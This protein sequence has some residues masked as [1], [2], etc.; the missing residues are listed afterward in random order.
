MNEKAIARS[1]DWYVALRDEC[2]AIVV[3]KSKIAQQELT[4]MYLMLGAR[5]LEEA[6]N[7][8]V[9]KI[10]EAVSTDIRIGKANLWA[11]VAVVKKFGANV[12]KL[13]IEGAMVSWSKT[14]RLLAPDDALPGRVEGA[15]DVDPYALANKLWSQHDHE[16]CRI[17]G[18]QL[19]RLWRERA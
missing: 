3:E 17:L 16:S 19:L 13:P 5:I 15:R 14:K 11:A 10:V 2:H 18:E 6:K 4:E 8:P 12:E 7:A 9:T 1:D